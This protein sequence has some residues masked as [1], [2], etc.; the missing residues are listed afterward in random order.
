MSIIHAR[1]PPTPPQV[2]PAAIW[3]RS[4][5]DLRV[6]SN[7]ISLKSVGQSHAAYLSRYD[8][9]VCILMRLFVYL[10]QLA[11]YIGFSFSLRS[12]LHLMFLEWSLTKISESWTKPQ[13][14]PWYQL[15]KN[16]IYAH[17]D[18]VSIHA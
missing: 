15:T 1:N 8:M 4:I 6:T 5:K 18:H 7:R 3:K 13:L 17:T 10:F 9:L 16:G 11:R 14:L 12:R 2:Q